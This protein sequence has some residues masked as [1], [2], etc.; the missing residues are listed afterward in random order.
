MIRIDAPA[1]LRSGG[2]VLRP[3]TLA[4]VPA[5][6]AAVLENVDHLLAFMP[7]ASYEPA[8]IGEREALVVRWAAL[9]KSGEQ[10]QCGTFLDGTV[11][12]AAG[13]RQGTSEGVLEI[14]Y[15]VHRAFTRRGIATVA[16]F[17]LTGLGFA[18]DE[19]RAVEIHHDRANV[20]SGGVP[21][22]LGF[23][24]VGEVRSPAPPPGGEGIDC[25]WRITRGSF[26][27]QRDRPPAVSPAPS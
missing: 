24:F 25:V 27:R 1:Q 14:G 2:L 8:P 26:E 9:A 20:A 5:F 6:H 4:D 3:W 23:E 22:K 19:T 13:L 15:W 18:M 7:W 11:V 12:G 17:L 16:S 10:W 21:R